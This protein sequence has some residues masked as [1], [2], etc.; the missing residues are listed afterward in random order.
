[1][2]VP[3]R[4]DL[5]RSL[6]SRAGR[7]LDWLQADST[8]V[9][10]GFLAVFV[11]VWFASGT[12][13]GMGGSLHDDMLEAYVWGREFQLGYNQHPP[14]WAWIAGAWFMVFPNTNWSFVLLAVLNSALGLAG[15]WRLI[16][17]FTSGWE[18]RAAVLLLLCTPFYTFKCYT[19]NAN[20]IFLSLW[21]WTYYFFI[22]AIDTRRPG[23][24]ALFGMMVGLC[25]LSKYYAI[26]LILSCFGA[27]FAHPAWRQYYRSASPWI[28]V[29]VAAILFLPHVVW[30]VLSHAP[31]LEYALSRTGIGA[32]SAIAN[33]LNVLIEIALFHV[34]VAAIVLLSRRPG[35]DNG[36]GRLDTVRSG[37]RV[38]LTALVFLPVVLTVLFAIGLELKLAAQMAIGIFPLLPLWLLVVVPA[39][40]NR[41]AFG[42]AACVA[43]GTGALSLLASPAVARYTF[44]WSRNDAAWVLPQKELAREATRLWRS[45][46]HA[47]LRFVGGSKYFGHAVAF[48]SED[49]PSGFVFLSFRQAPWVTP[50][51]L[52]RDGLLAVCLRGD[53][54]CIEAATHLMQPGARRME[55]SLSHAFW[56]LER[57][58]VT[59]DIFII[60]PHP[61]TQP[62]AG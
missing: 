15:A 21:P 4:N 38:F 48:Y 28:A 40:N 58:P 32:A 52:L 44:M 26:V 24:A 3:V 43:V 50:Q 18:R 22:R 36:A 19:Y 20:S 59:I 39:V 2:I 6:V 23:H 47:P 8:I 41:L 33:S 13:I 46:T 11:V 53:A 25:L 35:Q 34:V 27:S 60:P 51:A 9:L 29:A 10:C 55:L 62:G 16:G 14:F 56:G 7:W 37:G 57:A 1:M 31:P 12:I 49:R 61:E 30:A 45:E 54:D 5:R 17:L 42:L